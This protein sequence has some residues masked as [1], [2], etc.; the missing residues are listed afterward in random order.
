[1]R[2]AFK[3]ILNSA[4]VASTLSVASAE[5]VSTLIT[6]A[7]ASGKTLDET[8]FVTKNTEG[9]ERAHVRRPEI[10]ITMGHDHNAH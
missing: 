2:H 5:P 7:W 9:R 1:M 8:Q 3:T 6:G 10:E 4:T